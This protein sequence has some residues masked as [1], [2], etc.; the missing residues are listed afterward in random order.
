MRQ[1]FRRST[2]IGL[3][4]LLAILVTAC[5]AKSGPAG[6]TSGNQ[7]A[8]TT[9]K[10]SA[11]GVTDAEI[12]LGVQTV[13]SGSLALSGISERDGLQI[14]ADQVNAAGGIN[15]RKVRI[16][17]L[18]D[19]GLPQEGLNVV[20]RLIN[21]EKVFAL[22]AG[23]GSGSQLP[24]METIRQS[25]TPFVASMSTNPTL[26]KSPDPH[27][28]R[29][30]ANDDTV[31]GG[32]IDYLV[33]S[34]HVKRPAIVYNSTDYGLG[35]LQATEARL[36]KYGLQY[37]AKEK[38][39]VGDTNFSAQMLRIKQANPDAVV[40]Y[41]F[42]QESGPIVKQGKELGL[43]VPYI[44]GG[45]TSTP[46]FPESAGEAGIGFVS[47]YVVPVLPDDTSKPVVKQYLDALNKQYNGK[48]PVGRPSLFDYLGY[49]AGKVVEQGLRAAGKDLNR[50]S[51]EDALNKLKDYNADGALFAVTF[52]PQDHEGGSKVAFIQVGKDMKF[53][54][55][56]YV[57]NVQK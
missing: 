56:D 22:V 26:V 37:V 32:I 33:E 18:D 9:A 30:Y 39:N 48:L 38:Y 50:Q 34:Q 36:K 54:L 16:L 27:V 52:A 41:G 53:H 25:G 1:R 5:G 14:W 6:P 29:V 7:P 19:K 17:F 40:V 10:S 23:S 8:P 13:M 21:E 44:G 43:D 35:G 15:G 55:I 12:V 24:V 57:A 2:F 4:L 46:L 42:A 20:R 47:A 45:A 31:G 51:F 49:G 28:F 3:S 11:P